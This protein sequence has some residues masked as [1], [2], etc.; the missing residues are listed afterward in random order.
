MR[1][2]LLVDYSKNFIGDLNSY[3]L[4][5][6]NDDISITTLETIDQVDNYVYSQGFD[7]VV[8]Y[9]GFVESREWLFDIPVRSYARKMTDIEL[10]KKYNIRCYGIIKNSEE[11]INHIMKDNLNLTSSFEDTERPTNVLTSED[12]PENLKGWT[13]PDPVPSKK[14]KTTNIPSYQVSDGNYSAQ[15]SATSVQQSPQTTQ[16]IQPQSSGS[17]VVR[18]LYDEYTGERIIY[19]DEVDNTQ[20]VKQP[21]QNISHNNTT[22]TNDSATAFSSSVPSSENEY[23]G[24]PQNQLVPM[25]QPQYS[26]YPSFQGQQPTYQDSYG[27]YIY[28]VIQIKPLPNNILPNSLPAP[29]NT[30]STP[31]EENKENLPA[32]G[33]FAKEIKPDSS[34]QKLQYKATDRFKKYEEEEQNKAKEIAEAEFE[35]D[36]GNVR[37]N[38]KCITVYSAKGGVGKTTISSELASFLALTSH[39]RGKYRVCIADFNI[40]FGDVMTTLEFDQHGATMTSWADDIRSRIERGEVPEDITYSRSEIE[41]WL[42]RKNETGLYALLAPTNN[43]DSMN[44]KEDELRVMVDNLIKNG[45]FDFVICDTGNNTRDSSWISLEKAD[46]VMMIVT[47]D[48]TTANCNNSFLQTAERLGF[49]M[50]KIKIVINM[51][52][53]TRTVGVAPEELETAFVS[54]NTLRPYRFETLAKIKQSDDV[55]K[56][57]NK[58]EPLIYVSNHDFTRSIGE[59]VKK[60]TGQERVLAAP[61]KESLFER[62]FKKR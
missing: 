49:D 46:I 34:I 25:N 53:P 41:V 18:P 33:E 2:V 13:T 16:A 27:N 15:P 7:I 1:K 44:I 60:I 56:S 43:A 11:L 30:I 32:V 3:L 20:L 50:D 39:G 5:N 31:T 47:Q 37:K 45:D 40:D 48:V 61:Q 54:K 28:E 36:M 14:E 6:E 24:T 52:R 26:Y 10:S 23:T 58:G 57:N 38:A 17:A 8:I 29:S 9:A 12:M 51:V 22:N 21:A 4:I 35:K 59:V 42:Q 55:I 62:V 19:D